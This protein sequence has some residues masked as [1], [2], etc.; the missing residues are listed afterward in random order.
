M[1]KFNFKKPRGKTGRIITTVVAVLLL[2]GVV[3]GATALFG[4][5]TTTINPGEFKLGSIGPDGR[6]VSSSTSIYTKEAFPCQGLRIV[7]DF[8][9]TGTFDVY[10]YDVNERLLGSALDKSDIYEGEFPGASLARIVY[11]PDVPDGV[12]ASEW[13]IGRLEVYGY[14]KQLTIT[15]DK[16]QVEYKSSTDL[17]DAEKATSG[18]FEKDN[19]GEVTENPAYT[20]S[21]KIALDGKY[22]Y[23]RIYVKY[24][25]DTAS[26]MDTEVMFGD[27][28]DKAIRVSENGKTV[29]DGVAYTF[30]GDA[31]I[32]GSWYSVIVEMPADATSLR[33][34]GPAEAEYR[35]YGVEVK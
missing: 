3:V 13:S 14:A 7:P 20:S 34:C 29:E 17:F 4:K 32:E 25:A 5:D 15:V 23:Y 28:E 6:S 2:F 8:E 30:D 19:I 18:Y 10:Y 11:T 27:E 24:T 1:A 21:E 22:D 16:E 12:K 35:I 33:I 9:A 26:S 31:M